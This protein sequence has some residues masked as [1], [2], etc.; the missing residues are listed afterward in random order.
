MA[1][2]GLR[3]VQS[4]AFMQ[5]KTIQPANYM[6]T[7]KRADICWLSNNYGFRQVEACLYTVP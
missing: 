6:S 3:T 1:A 5:G 4:S 7:E 2:T